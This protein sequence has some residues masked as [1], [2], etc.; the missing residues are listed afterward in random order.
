MHWCSYYTCNFFKNVATERK[1]SFKAEVLRR[2]D[3]QVMTS[4]NTQLNL[5]W[6]NMPL[7]QRQQQTSETGAQEGEGRDEVCV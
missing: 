5:V 7:T 1:H 3:R 4:S 6:D 2:I